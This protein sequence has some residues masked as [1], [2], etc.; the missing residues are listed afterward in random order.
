MNRP[1][2]GRRT[3]GGQIRWFNGGDSALELARMRFARGEL[4]REEFDTIRKG[5]T[6]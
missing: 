6:A 2:R 5:L 1:V 3:P 4:T